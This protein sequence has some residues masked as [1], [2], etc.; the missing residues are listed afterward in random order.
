MKLFELLQ[1]KWLGHPLHPAVVHVPIGLWTVATVLDLIAWFGVAGDVLP[2][3]S[4]ACVVLGLL[5]ALLA[6]PTGIADWAPIKK[7]KPAWRLGLYH[8]LLNLLATL[9]WA[10]NFGL[11]LGTPEPG[12]AITLPILLTSITGALLV[13]VGGYLGCR[14]VFDQGVSVARQSKKKWRA[15]AERGGSH[16]P[17]A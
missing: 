14:M 16:V 5:A 17:D 7:E 11:R 2:R 3:L 12:A 6:V 9:V 13:F 4:L 15:I 10:G 1:G 8:L